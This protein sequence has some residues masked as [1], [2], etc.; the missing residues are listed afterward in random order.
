MERNRKF[1]FKLCSHLGYKSVA[2]LENSLSSK[3]LYE[4]Y[5]YY[6]E[7][8]FMADRLE[9]MLATLTAITYNAHGGK[10]LSSIDF[11]ISVSKELKENIKAKEKQ[12]KIFEALD[13]FGT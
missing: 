13:S 10:D 9:V 8:Q 7:E 2:E 5:E 3:E 4:W 11:M 6:Q 12:K 1:L